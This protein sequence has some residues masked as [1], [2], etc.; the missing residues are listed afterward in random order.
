MQQR[1]KGIK[2]AISFFTVYALGSS[3]YAGGK[4]AE[5][6][7]APVTPIADT[8][9]PLPLYVGLG[10]LASAVSKDCPCSNADRL[11]DMT[12]GALAR[13]GWDFNQYIGLEARYL[14]APIEEDFSTTT[15]YGIFAKPQYH[16]TNQTNIY[17]LVGYGQTTVKGCGLNNGELKEAGLSYGI[18][19]EY[20]F[21]GEEGLGEYNRAFD[22]KGDQESGWGIWADYQNLFHNEGSTNTKTNVFS[23]GV[24]YDF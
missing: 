20:D 2:L 18:G 10:A 12:Y 14:N 15:H 17:A 4:Y 7:D 6:Q 1:S 21:S 5:P 8:V 3:A 24:T 11:K 19:F 23:V 13:I 16:I 22:G 9:N